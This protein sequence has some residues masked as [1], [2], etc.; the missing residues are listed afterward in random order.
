MKLNKYGYKK[1]ESEKEYWE[2]YNKW[3]KEFDKLNFKK[4]RKEP[5]KY[6]EEF[7][8]KLI[9]GAMKEIISFEFAKKKIK[10]MYKEINAPQE[11][12]MDMKEKKD[13]IKRK[14]KEYF[15][16]KNKNKEKE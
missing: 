11:F 10:R 13:Y 12:Q 15:K 8:K 1:I 2:E 16:G 14:V 3:K 7:E 6:I 5:Y 9:E 4:L